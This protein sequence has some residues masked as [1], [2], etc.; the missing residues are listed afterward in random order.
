MKE[1][2][3][4]ASSDGEISG[5]GVVKWYAKRWG[6][7]PQFRDVKDIHFGMGLSATHIKSTERRDRLLFIHALSTVILTILG[8]AGENIGLDRYLKA[9]TVKRRTLSLF[10]QGCI[11]FNRIEKMFEDTL[12]KLLNE[13]Y[14]LIEGNKLF[15]N[16]LGVI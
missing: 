16:V 7:E 3:C 14:R 9:N 13:F 10:R 1:P 5:S 8:A 11:Y 2:W 12:K 4:I 6:C 15:T